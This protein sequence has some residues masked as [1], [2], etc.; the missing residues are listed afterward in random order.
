MLAVIKRYSL[1]VAFTLSLLLGLQIPNFLQQYE[2]RLQGH[3]AEAQLQL[4]QFQ[5]L[6]DTYFEGDL[7]ALIRKH[8]NSQVALFRDEAFV[9]EQSYLRVQMLQQK[10]DNIKQPIWMRLGTVSQE[11][12]QPIFKES[13]EG[14]QANIVLNQQAIVV[15]LTVAVLLMLLLELFFY[16]QK[17]CWLKVVSLCKP[18]VIITKQKKTEV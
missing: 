14:Y 8:K 1:L 15:G 18:K 11:V 10:I 13:W 2:M 12:T 9:I 5:L 7:K 16:L 6:A 3:F 17:L 4:A